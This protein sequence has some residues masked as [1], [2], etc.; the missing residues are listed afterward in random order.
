M[1][2]IRYHIHVVFDWFHQ[3]HAM[4]NLISDNNDGIL[5]PRKLSATLVNLVGNF[6]SVPT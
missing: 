6:D 2:Y 3:H 5:K 1:L 4:Q